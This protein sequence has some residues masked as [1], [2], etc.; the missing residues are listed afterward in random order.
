MPG[1]PDPKRAR[2]AA[3]VSAASDGDG[4]DSSGS[5]SASEASEAGVD[6]RAVLSLRFLCPGAEAEGKVASTAHPLY[7]HQIF[8]DDRIEGYEG[9]RERGLLAREA[10]GECGLSQQTR[11]LVHD[12]RSLSHFSPPLFQASAS[13]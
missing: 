3:A 6:A 4:G 2:R 13:T 10:K 5:P 11:A 9:G 8:E 12:P 1:E 7:T